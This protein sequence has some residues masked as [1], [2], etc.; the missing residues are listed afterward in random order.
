MAGEDFGYYQ[1]LAVRTN[2]SDQIGDYERHDLRQKQNKQ[3]ASAKA[4]LFADS[5]QYNNAANEFDNKRIKEIND[6]KVREIGAFYKE[7]P[8]VMYN[9]DKL[10]ILNQMKRSLVDN[11]EVL[12]GKASDDNFKALNADLQEV[13]KNPQMHN[14]LAYQK[15]LEQKENYLKYGNQLG[16]E[17]SQKEGFKPFVYQKPAEFIDLSKKGSDLGNNF[18]DLKP[19]TLKNGRSG[20][21][22][23]VANE[24]SLDRDAQAFYLEHKE[25]FDQQ[26][27]QDGLKVAKELIRSGINQKFDWGDNHFAEQLA[28]MKL[29][30]QADIDKARAK[31]GNNTGGFDYFRETIQ[32]KK[33]G[34]DTPERLDATFGS[35]PKHVIKNDDGSV[36]IDNTGDVFNYNG[37]FQDV[38]NGIKRLSGYVYKPLE[39][40]KQNGILNENSWYIPFE[41]E[42]EA[43]TD[44]KVDGS[45]SQKASIIDSPVDKDGKSQ[46]LLKIKTFTDVDS[47]SPAYQGKYNSLIATTD[48]RNAVTP[49]QIGGTQIFEDSAGNAFDA[50]GNY[51]GKASQFK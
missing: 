3:L 6:I 26:H 51:L 15:L 12:R 25:Q 8:D 39:W 14:Q 48:Q 5:V 31:A 45:W 16:L 28:L 24:K 34:A 2:L 40:G 29:Q 27:G 32:N 4:Q 21:W 46:K 19:V 43:G 7:N 47:N 37:D 33:I 11:P 10:V 44:Y 38:G 9:P 13:A 42:G 50:K 22:Q 23:T 1:G 41:S 18:K 35:K 30:T 17:A 49:Q 20:A 36:T